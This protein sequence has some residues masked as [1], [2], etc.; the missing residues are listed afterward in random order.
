MTEKIIITNYNHETAETTEV[1]LTGVE[2][3]EF[4]AM[5]EESN[6]A[7]IAAEQARLDKEATKKAALARVGLTEEEI[8]LILGIDSEGTV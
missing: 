5:R 1:E 7:L 8:N 3:E 2:R 6:A 4:I